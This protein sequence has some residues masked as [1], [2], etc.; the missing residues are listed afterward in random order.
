MVYSRDHSRSYIFDTRIESTVRS[1]RWIE[2]WLNDSVIALE[3]SELNFVICRLIGDYRAIGKWKKGELVWQRGKPRSCKGGE[4][5]GGE[6][7]K[8]MLCDGSAPGEFYRLP[9]FPRV[10]DSLPPRGFRKWRFSNPSH[11]SVST[12]NLPDTLWIQCKSIDDAYREG[13]NPTPGCPV[14]WSLPTPTV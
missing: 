7:F 6:R 3:E 12:R 5:T 1:A 11:P 14:V 4:E 9:C 8:E 13:S 2:I 10:H